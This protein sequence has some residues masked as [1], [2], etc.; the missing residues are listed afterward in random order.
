MPRPFRVSFPVLVSDETNN[1][2]LSVQTSV[3]VSVEAESAVE[4]ARFV[5]LHLQP[6]LTTAAR[7]VSR[8]E[9]IPVGMTMVLYYERPAEG[10]AVRARTYGVFEGLSR[11]DHTFRWSWGIGEVRQ[12][13][14]LSLLELHDV[15]HVHRESDP[16]GEGEDAPRTPEVDVVDV[17]VTGYF[18]PTVRED[19][20]SPLRY[21]PG[22]ER[23]NSG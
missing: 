22:G 10:D 2:A 19:Y 4:A 18:E 7:R 23:V 14:Q 15:Q 13:F 11:A 6:A 1:R 17:Y 21:I 16:L 3:S 8:L 5:G 12:T 20:N 9:Q